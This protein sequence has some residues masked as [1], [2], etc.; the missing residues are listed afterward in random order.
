[1]YIKTATYRAKRFRE[2]IE[3]I[4]HDKGR[5]D[6]QNTFT[7]KHNLR[8]DTLEG[9]IKEFQDNDLYRKKRKR[10]IVL[11]HEMLS[12]HPEDKHKISMDILEQTA[13]KFIEL[14]GQHALC[15]AKPHI[16]NDNIH[17]HFCF[18]G[19]ELNSSKTLR[20][21][22]KRFRAIRLEMERFQNRFPELS[23]SIVYLN[24]W[25]KD[26]VISQE[27]SIETR[28]ETQLKKRTGKKSNKEIVSELLQNCYQE[29]I[30]KDDFFQ[31]L[32]DRGLG[33]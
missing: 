16:E 28:K 10:G 27:K 31:R 2:V 1:M 17:I 21:E 6:E 30:S 14:R 26:K 8:S 11:Y 18:S 25:E 29:S 7:I 15:F 12:Y 24:K 22:K 5:I 3:Y 32:I 33:L 9:I 13:Q 19:N 23:N 4:N 20:L